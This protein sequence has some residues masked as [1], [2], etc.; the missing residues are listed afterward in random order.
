[1]V[2]ESSDPLQDLCHATQIHTDQK[3]T[4]SR[5]VVG[6]SVPVAH[7]NSTGARPKT[8]PPPPPVP[9]PKQE[10][11]PEPVTRPHVSDWNAPRSVEIERLTTLM[12]DMWRQY[13]WDD[14][15]DMIWKNRDVLRRG[16]SAISW[17]C[18]LDRTS[19]RQL[20]AWYQSCSNFRQLRDDFTGQLQ[21][22]AHARNDHDPENDLYTWQ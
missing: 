17:A 15:I 12:K 3:I 13:A 14:G 6:P 16:T 11:N 4:N 7:S 5:K 20:S 22:V 18:Q 2:S 1:M 8:P 10:S 9:R 21:R 19:R